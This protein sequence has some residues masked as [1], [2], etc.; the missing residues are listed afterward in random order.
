MEKEHNHGLANGVREEKVNPH[1]RI[2]IPF[3]STLH[4]KK[5]QLTIGIVGKPSATQKARRGESAGV[6]VVVFLPAIR[7]LN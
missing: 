6:G 1:T 3:N 5:K 7:C 4:G 2:V